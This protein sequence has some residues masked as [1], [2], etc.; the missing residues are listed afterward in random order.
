ML[1]TSAEPILHYALCI[2][3]IGSSADG[4]ATAGCLSGNIR[5]VISPSHFV[6]S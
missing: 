2:K 3:T 4:F 5:F 1:K 6:G